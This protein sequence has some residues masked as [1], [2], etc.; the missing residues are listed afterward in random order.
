M[1][2]R[3]YFD[4]P[5]IENSCRWRNHTPWT[6][7]TVSAMEAHSLTRVRDLSPSYLKLWCPLADIQA[8]KGH[9]TRFRRVE[10]EPLSATVQGLAQRL[11]D[12]EKVIDQAVGNI[13]ASLGRLCGT[14]AQIDRIK[15]GLNVD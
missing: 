8:P 2:A 3:Q 4:T 7:W 13:D 15:Q 9:V 11:L 5:R 14:Q 10:V 12:M 1:S 6:E